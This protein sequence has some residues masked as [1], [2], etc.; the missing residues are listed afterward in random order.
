MQLKFWLD[1]KLIARALDGQQQPWVARVGFKLLPQPRDMDVNGA[2]EGLAAQAPDFL[3]QLFAGDHGTASLDEVFEQTEFGGGKG[4]GFAAASDLVL[5]EIDPNVSELDFLGSCGDPT[6]GASQERL[7]PRHEFDDRAVFLDIIVGAQ[8]K[9]ENTVNEFA[10]RG[11]HQNRRGDTFAAEVATDVEA[12]LA[13]KHDVENDEVEGARE[14]L[15]VSVGAVGRPLDIVSLGAQS[16]DG[17][18]GKSFFVLNEQDAGHIGKWMV[19]ALPRPGSLL[20]VTVPLWAAVALRTSDR[21]R[22][23]PGVCASVAA[24]PRANGSNI[25]AC[26][27]GS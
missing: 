18:D 20:T 14:G 11:K 16:V 7:Y 17:A 9:S 4:D 2:A 25:S 3:E 8:F 10:A 24:S 1:S 6:A 21:P 26:A 5:A 23:E 19:K 13:G 22:P 12:L 27:A 15:G